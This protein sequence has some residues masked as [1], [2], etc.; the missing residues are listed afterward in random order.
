MP[1]Y[2]FKDSVNSIF[3]TSGFEALTDAKS[4]LA[5]NVQS[6]VAVWDSVTKGSGDTYR[7]TGPKMQTFVHGILAGPATKLIK[8]KNTDSAVVTSR[9]N[10]NYH[11]KIIISYDSATRKYQV[12]MPGAQLSGPVLEK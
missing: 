3:P 4:S 2:I 9:D 8:Y 5:T 1:E 10:N 7:V 12:W 6:M 11:G